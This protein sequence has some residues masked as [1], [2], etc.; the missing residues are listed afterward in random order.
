ML[1]GIYDRVPIHLG[2]GKPVLA[3]ERE[4]AFCAGLVVRLVE[5]V[6]GL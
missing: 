6:A 3:I 1:S 5:N 2:M 4:Q